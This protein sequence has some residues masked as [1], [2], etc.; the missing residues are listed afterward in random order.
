[1][2]SV[3]CLSPTTVRVVFRQ[4]LSVVVDCRIVDCMKDGR[5]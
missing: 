3:V 1:M 2:Y 5:F 4:L